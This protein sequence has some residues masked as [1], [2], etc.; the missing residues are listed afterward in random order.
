MD[1]EMNEYIRS[2][3]PP[4]ISRLMSPDLIG[5]EENDL[6]EIL[7]QSRKEFFAYQKRVEE[8][9][10]EKIRLRSEL[11]MPLSRLALLRRTTNRRKEKNYFD[12]IIRRTN[13]RLYNDLKELPVLPQDQAYDFQQFL[14]KNL[15]S[16]LFTKIVEICRDCT[17][18]KIK[19]D[20][21]S[22]QEEFLWL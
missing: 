7:E 9:E 20:K 13:H 18:N 21:S 3:D 4:Q 8:E 6:A 17:S 15:N 22:R 12:F 1:E 11:G 2:P 5:E 16:T 19:F 14:Q 10:R